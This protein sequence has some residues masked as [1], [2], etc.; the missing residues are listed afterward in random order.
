MSATPTS[1]FIEVMTVENALLVVV[2]KTKLAEQLGVHRNTVG[3]MNG[4]DLLTV[5]RDGSAIARFELINK[6]M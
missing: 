4:N 3:N 2:T 1:K 6:G 5:F